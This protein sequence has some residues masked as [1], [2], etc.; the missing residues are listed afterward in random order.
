[1]SDLIQ[2]AEQVKGLAGDSSLPKSKRFQEGVQAFSGLVLTEIPDDVRERF[3]AD[4]AGV[5]EV[6]ARYELEYDE[7]SQIASGLVA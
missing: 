5:N 4:L 6:L 7:D 1:M 2:R 3:E